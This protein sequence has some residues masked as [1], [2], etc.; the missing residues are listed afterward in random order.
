[1]HLLEALCASRHGRRFG[2]KVV[3]ELFMLKMRVVSLSREQ[4]QLQ[5]SM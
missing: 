4:G 5:S 2:E 1:M 3:L